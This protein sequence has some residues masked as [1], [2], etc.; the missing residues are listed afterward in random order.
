MSS[1][2]SGSFNSSLSLSNFFNN[3]SKFRKKSSAT[4]LFSYL[5][6]NFIRMLII[7]TFSPF[8]L[9]AD[10]H[11]SIKFGA[12]QFLPMIYTFSAQNN[13]VVLMRRKAQPTHDCGMCTF[14]FGGKTC[15]WLINP[16]R[17]T[18][19]YFR[20]SRTVIFINLFVFS[21]F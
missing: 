2:F 19:A 14:V 21:K 15:R 18:E 16:N 10:L 13:L 12:K 4:A 8:P 11:V 17:P 7:L 5:W 9:P 3:L 6:Y 1:C 20:Y